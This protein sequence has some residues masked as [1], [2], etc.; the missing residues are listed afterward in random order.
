MQIK[1][2]VLDVLP[3]AI[4]VALLPPIWATVS[5]LFGITFGWV[6]LACAGMYFIIG[7]PVKS[8]IKTSVSFFDGMPLGSRGNTNDQLAANKQNHITVCRTLR[9]GIRSR[10]L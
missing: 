2:E 3:T 10:N 4:G 1:N 8:G 6:S 7:D 5:A 9:I